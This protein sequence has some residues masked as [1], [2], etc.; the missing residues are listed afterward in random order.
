MDVKSIDEFLQNVWY[1]RH[2]ISMAL[3]PL[4]WLYRALGATRKAAYTSG[5]LSSYHA[6]VPIVVV[7]NIT[8]GGTGKTPLVIWLVDYFRSL[9]YSPGVVAR[10]YRGRAKRWPQQ[11]RPDS[12][13]TVVGDEPIVI[14]RRARCPVAV[15]P[16]RGEAV[17]AL[18]R[19]A[20]C[21]IV[22]SDDGLQHYALERNYE[23]AVIDGVRRMGNGRC[24]PAGPLREPASRLDSV[25]LIVT[26]GIAGR[27]EFAMKYVATHAR[28]IDGSEQIELSKFDPKQVHAVAGIAHP[29]RYFSMLRS[30]GFRVIAHSFRDHARFRQ[31]DLEF[32]DDLPIIMTEKDAIK[33]EHLDLPRCWYVPITA[34]LPEVFRRRL[35][36]VFSGVDDG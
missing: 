3:A 29:E 27:G 25:D 24:L 19:Y 2:P 32:G 33:C 17:D 28:S 30:K 21:D 14:A 23:I 9:G 31:S 5:L 15:G 12:D 18:L 35:S 8:S 16:R 4:G 10:G 1:T 22:I 13:P 7:G 20:D 26:N 11:V 6:E 34:S 36:F